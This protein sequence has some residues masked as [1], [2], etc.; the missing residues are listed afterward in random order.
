MKS[1]EGSTQLV[2]INGPRLATAGTAEERRRI[3]SQLMRRLHL[4]RQEQEEQ[5]TGLTNPKKYEFVEELSARP[6]RVS[7]LFCISREVWINRITESGSQLD[8]QQE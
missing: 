5:A 4:E 2:F 6:C 8:R 7:R 1:T 3:R